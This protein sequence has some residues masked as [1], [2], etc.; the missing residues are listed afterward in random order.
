MIELAMGAYKDGIFSGNSSDI[1]WRNLSSLSVVLLSLRQHA[2]A[3]G[4]M[5]P[6]YT[7]NML[8]TGG[9]WSCAPCKPL[10]LCIDRNAPQDTT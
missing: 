9:I 10:L 6:H 4:H 7:N 1:P 8:V 5:I 2:W 3:L